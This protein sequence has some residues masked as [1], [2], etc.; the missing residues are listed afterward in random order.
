MILDSI[1]L[2]I[3]IITGKRKIY[4]KGQRRDTGTPGV[5]GY[6]DEEARMKGLLCLSFF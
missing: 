6:S 4:E 1:R 5:S 3:L 2:I